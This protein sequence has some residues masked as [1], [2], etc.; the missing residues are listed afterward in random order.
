MN[1]LTPGIRTMP[2]RNGT[3]WRDKAGLGAFDHTEGATNKSAYLVDA[4]R[5]ACYKSHDL[6]RAE[7]LCPSVR[8]SIVEPVVQKASEAIRE[9]N[10]F[11]ADLPLQQN[12]NARQIGFLQV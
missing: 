4:L 10:P 5:C 12:S 6:R 9:A 3:R 8:I 1:R 7:M 11:F 2:E